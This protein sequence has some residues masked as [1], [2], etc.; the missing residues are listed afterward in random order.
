M[1]PNCML[2]KAEF[3]FFKISCRN[4]GRPENGVAETAA[5]AAG[6]QV[7]AKRIALKLWGERLKSCWHHR[8]GLRRDPVRNGMVF[9]SGVT[10]HMR[11]KGGFTCAL[12]VL[13]QEER[14]R[15]PSS[16]WCQSWNMEERWKVN[17]MNCVRKRTWMHW[18]STISKVLFCEGQ[19]NSPSNKF[20]ED[21]KHISDLSGAGNRE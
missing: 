9:A 12:G 14:T 19:K 11:T 13:S 7:K 17:C 15:A 5:A 3:Y 2:G 4:E 21:R 10:V 8:L 18:E 16:A 1:F 20:F 6:A